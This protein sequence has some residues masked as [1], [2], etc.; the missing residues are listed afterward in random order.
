[1][2]MCKVLKAGDQVYVLSRPGSFYYRQ[3]R[4]EHVYF[5]AI[6]I[7]PIEDTPD[8]EALLKAVILESVQRW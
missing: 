1:M 5:E 8:Y 6:T 7:L 2:T 4:R 3:C